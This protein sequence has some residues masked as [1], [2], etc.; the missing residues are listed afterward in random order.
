MPNSIDPTK[1]RLIRDIRIYRRKL[2]GTTADKVALRKEIKDELKA[3]DGAKYGGIVD[4]DLPKADV[5]RDVMSF[6]VKGK[7]APLHD[8]ATGKPLVDTIVMPNRLGGALPLALDANRQSQ[9]QNP[10]TEVVDPVK[11]TTIPFD[12]KNIKIRAD[13]AIE[14]KDP[15]TGAEIEE[16]HDYMHGIFNIILYA[17]RDKLELINDALEK[18]A[19]KA[20]FF[21][22][23][24][25]PAAAEAGVYLSRITEF[26]D[27]CESLQPGGSSPYAEAFTYVGIEP[28][29]TNEGFIV[30]CRVKLNWKN[31]YHSSS[32][33]KVP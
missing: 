14:H 29:V 25:D 18:Y 21:V 8:T 6:Q 19:E 3:K 2:P 5:Y 22:G 31:P 24:V 7:K 1:A 15:V 27:Y 23:P 28:V 9:A 26:N 10:A 13:G 12:G 33:I 30:S 11:N 32:T 16:A 4:A 20:V 17:L